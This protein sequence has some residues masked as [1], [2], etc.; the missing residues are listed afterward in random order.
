MNKTTN[1]RKNQYAYHDSMKQTLYR[2]LASIIR[3]NIAIH[4]IDHML[5][6]DI[7]AYGINWRYTTTD[8]KNNHTIDIITQYEDHINNL[9]F[10]LNID[11][12]VDLMV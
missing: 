5:I 7:S 2:D 12:E 8:L 9:F 10:N 4:I 1:K 11:K 6:V 3:G